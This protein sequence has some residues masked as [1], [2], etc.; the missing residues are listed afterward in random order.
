MDPS[1]ASSEMTTTED[2]T[3]KKVHEVVMRTSRGGLPGHRCYEREMGK[4]R[5]DCY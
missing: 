1:S 2:K 4:M 3:V 5:R